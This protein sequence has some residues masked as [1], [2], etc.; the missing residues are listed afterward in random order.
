MWPSLHQLQGRELQLVLSET[1]DSRSSPSDQVCRVSWLL[2]V[3]SFLGMQIMSLKNLII[4]FDCSGSLLLQG[5]FLVV[6]TGRYSL[7]AAA[8]GIRSL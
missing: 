5:H 2:T 1:A 3:L 4:Y 8:Q 6:V 7:V